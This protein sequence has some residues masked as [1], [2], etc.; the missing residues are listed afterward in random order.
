[1]STWMDSGKVDSSRAPLTLWMDVWTTFHAQSSSL[2]RGWS[3]HMHVSPY[4]LSVC[5]TASFQTCTEGVARVAV[6]V[7]VNLEPHRRGCHGSIRLPASP[8]PSWVPM[9]P[10]FEREKGGIQARKCRGSTFLVARRLHRSLRKGRFVE[11]SAP[12][13][14][15]ASRKAGFAGKRYRFWTSVDSRSHSCACGSG[16]AKQLQARWRKRS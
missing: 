14:P 4:V 2:F 12:C 11:G 9:P 13:D 5:T 1:M 15:C 3:V 8:K 6:Y 16:T 7:P 10:F